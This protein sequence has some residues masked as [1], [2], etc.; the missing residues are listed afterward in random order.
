MMAP[1]RLP[2]EIEERLV[3]MSPAPGRTENF[4]AFEAALERICALEDIYMA[5]ERLAHLRA[6]RTET[7]RLDD[8]I[9]QFGISR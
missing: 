7:I 6:G 8:L 9:R 5:E 1:F 3:N 2:A 4:R